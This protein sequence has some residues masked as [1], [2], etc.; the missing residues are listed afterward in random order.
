[1]HVLLLYFSSAHFYFCC[2]VFFLI[3]CLPYYC[4]VQSEFGFGG[5]AI[6]TKVSE[7]F[8]GEINYKV[9]DGGFGYSIENTK[10]IVSDQVIVLDNIDLSFVVGE[11]LTDTV[12]N[13]GT[14]VGQNTNI[15]GVK[16]IA[17]NDFSIAET[18]STV[19]RTINIDLDIS[20]VTVKNLTS[21]GPMFADTGDANN[22]IVES[23]S[24]Q[25]VIQIL[26]Q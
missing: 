19:N 3:I 9:E 15:V 17:N 18:I 2:I 1:M 23:L 22:V 13:T 14:V 24:N 5:T 21:P 16:M 7:E 4:D 25:E 26:Y 6:V 11:T 10:L 20:D 12:G 8:T